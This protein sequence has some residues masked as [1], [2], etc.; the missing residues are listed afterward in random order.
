MKECEI[1]RKSFEKQYGRSA[2]RDDVLSWLAEWYLARNR[3]ADAVIC[4]AEIP[5]S[6]PVYG[7]MA[8]YQQ[9]RSLLTLHRAI[10]AEQ[11]LRELIEL[12]EITPTISQELLVDARQLLRHILE[13]ELRFEERHL[14]LKGVVARG[15]ADNFEVVAACFPSQLRW[16]G[17]QAIAWMDEFYSV[18]STHTV[19]RIAKGRYLTG[20]GKLQEARQ[21]LEAVI[22]E[23]PLD[24]RAL[25]AL[26]ACLTEA[27]APD[28]VDQ[29]MARL[30]PSTARD[31]WLLLLQR[32]DHAL[33]NGRAKE[34]MAAYERV[35]Q[36]DRSSGQAWMGIA[37]AAIPLGD[38]PK[39][40]H[41][42]KMATGLGRIQNHLD[43]GL[44]QASDPNSFMD[45][46][47]LCA[48]LGMDREGWVMTEF[49]RKFAPQNRRVLAHVE[50][51]KSRLAPGPNSSPGVK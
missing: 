21:L 3:L 20:Q 11:Q 45:V 22:I 16:N 34:A 19:M 26:I 10:D 51:F 4:F 43:K 30:P 50:L 36:S 13:V 2:D 1:A 42:L 47:D 23:S 32:G 37:N 25:A 8:R 17:P 49:A 14:L 31:P 29:L 28:E 33:R 12:E 27:D 7:R 44:R 38:M 39:R 9:G 18:D 40:A 46:A 24:L 5:S 48:D 15:E 35:I 41:A 6:H